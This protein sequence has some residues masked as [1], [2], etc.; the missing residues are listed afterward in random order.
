MKPLSIG[1]FWIYQGTDG[2]QALKGLGVLLAL[3]RVHVA[4]RAPLAPAKWRLGFSKING[5]SSEKPWEHLILTTLDRYS[6]I[7]VS[8]CIFSRTSSSYLALGPGYFPPEISRSTLEELSRGPIPTSKHIKA[9][10]V[11]HVKQL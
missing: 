1:D 4:G 9:Y 6:K 2:F 11:P 3:S 10:H 8:L 7:F 5:F